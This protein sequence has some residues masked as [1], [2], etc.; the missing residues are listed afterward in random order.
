V[1]DGNVK[2]VEKE[3]SSPF[4]EVNDDDVTNS[5]ELLKDP[6]YTS[7]KPFP[8]RMAKAKLDLQVGRVLICP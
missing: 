8:Q 1:N 4:K 6:K 5:N 7:R 3:V 2:I